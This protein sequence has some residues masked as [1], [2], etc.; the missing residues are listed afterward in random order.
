MFQTDDGPTDGAA[1][2]QRGG[3]PGARQSGRV[4][5]P[6]HPKLRL[7][8]RQALRGRAQLADLA[9]EAARVLWPVRQRHR[10]PRDEGPHHAGQFSSLS[11]IFT[12]LLKLWK[13]IISQ[14]N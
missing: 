6:F 4:Q 5:R 13:K 9:R 11:T 3:G 8:S 10:R 2:V 14:I 1:A 12:Q 7:R